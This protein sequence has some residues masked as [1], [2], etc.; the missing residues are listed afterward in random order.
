L[1]SPCPPTGG[2]GTVYKLVPPSSPGGSWTEKVLHRFANRKQDGYYPYAGLVIGP[3]GAL[4][5]TTVYGGNPGGGTAFEVLP[6]AAGREVWT[7]T[8]IHTFSGENGDGNT[9]QCVLAVGANGV[10]YGTTTGGGTSHL[11]TVFELTPPAS[12]GGAWTE[13]ILYSFTGAPGD[14]GSPVAGVVIGSG[15]VLYGTT[16]HGGASN[17]GSVFQLSPPAPGGVLWTE[18]VLYSF[19][20]MNGDGTSPIGGL[21]IGANGALYGTDEAGGTPGHG[22]VF[23]LAPPTSSGGLWTETTLYSF[24]GL[25]DEN[26]PYSSLVFGKNGVLYGT[27]LGGNAFAL[28]PPAPGGASWKETVSVSLGGGSFGGLAIKSNG[29]LY[30]TTPT[31]GIVFRLVP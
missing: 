14:G 5:G 18:T 2:C 20:G 10:I 4:Y 8:V 31:P 12:P 22:T 26:A 17:N 27:T 15:G 21:V 19:T 16:Q 28:R 24:T 29:V 11:G 7:E 25:G 3:N 1:S 23:E 30:G 13:T 9:P 6:P